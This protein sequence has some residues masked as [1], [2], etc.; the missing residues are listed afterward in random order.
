MKKE[1]EIKR[2]IIRLE[3]KAEESKDRPED[4]KYYKYKMSGLKWV[5]GNVCCEE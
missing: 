1:S 4:F 3:K 2:E 5:L